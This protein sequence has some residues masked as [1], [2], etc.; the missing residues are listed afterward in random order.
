MGISY[1][2]PLALSLSQQESP[3]AA[4]D[5]LVAAISQSLT[6]QS[7]R[8]YRVRITSYRQNTKG[9]PAR[10]MYLLTEESTAPSLAAASTLSSSSSFGAPAN[11]STPAVRGATG[12]TPYSLCESQGTLGLPEIPLIGTH[13][14]T[15]SPEM[16]GSPVVSDGR[17]LEQ[18]LAITKLHTPLEPTIVSG[19]RFQAGDFVLS[20][21]QVTRAQRFH[22]V[23]AHAELLSVADWR[24]GLQVFKR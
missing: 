15:F 6:P 2:F 8:A 20:V 3:Q 13:A 14:L 9:G 7:Q 21:G 24:P 18:L 17:G 22:G 19:M 16:Q 5:R 1:L 10:E 12:S 23:I 11:A 4:F